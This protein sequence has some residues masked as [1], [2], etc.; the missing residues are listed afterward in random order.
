MT[1][2]R[3]CRGSGRATEVPARSRCARG[4]GSVG[5]KPKDGDGTGRGGMVG[6]TRRACV[7][8]GMGVVVAGLAFAGSGSGSAAAGSGGG[9]TAAGSGGRGT[10][11]GAGGGRAVAGASGGVPVRMVLPAPTGPY[12]VGG[13]AL[14]LV[15]EGRRDPWVAGRA[16]RE[17]MVSVRY[18][19]GTAGGCARVPQMLPGEAAAFAAWSN[20]SKVMSE[21]MADW[22]ATRTHA[23][24]GA[25]VAQP[26]GRGFPVVLHSPG[27]A[28][29]RGLGSTL[30]DELASR[31]YVVVSIDHTYEAP[32]VQF[33]DGRV[34]YSRMREEAGK[35][36]RP[37]QVVA[38]LKKLTAV[39]VADT[40]FV[41]DQLGRAVVL[42]RM[43]GG[44]L[45]LRA[46]G[47]FGHSGGGFTAAQAMHDD[48][49]IRAAVNMDGV[50]GYTQRDDDPANPS[51]VGT[52]GLD[53]PLLLMGKEGDDH[54][55][56]ASWKAVWERSSGW[57]L[58]LTLTGAGHAS[59]TDAQSLVPQLARK[60]G[61]PREAVEELVG[62]V[63]PERSV[64]A[65]RAYVTAFFDRWLR[66][67]D[68]GLLDGPSG[69]F[70]E[71]RFVR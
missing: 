33:P 17:L 14:R 38:L 60:A 31:G 47:M 12:G 15:D 44:V 62:T 32:G 49:R 22:G 9:R 7:V 16:C 56:V 64:A 54:H 40:R 34:E 42:P 3:R 1:G 68:S 59:F 6:R 21:G 37:E 58:D 26:G 46:V 10:V 36:Q 2:C 45:D 41:L 30:C 51:T 57:H 20:F 71:I 11:A 66:G 53:R 24:R 18:P 19:A 50:M 8:T 27:A 67:R 4:C 63:A 65:Q 43:P 39:R 55:T 61:L 13:V 35:A 25:P 48:R 52:D 69:R 5:G 28:D 70:P 29:P 23:W